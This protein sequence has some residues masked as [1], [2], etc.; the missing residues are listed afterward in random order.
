M[1]QA[2]NFPKN[3]RS[4]PRF[5]LVLTLLAIAFS[6]SA[7]AHA[8]S[9]LADGGF[10]AAG[11]GNVY[12]ATSTIDGGSWTVTQGA[13]YIDNLDPWVYDGANSL[14]LTGANLYAP[15]SIDQILTTV[16]GQQYAVNFWANA[17]ISNTF[18][19]TQ[20]GLSVSGAPTSIA[21]NGFPD[22]IDPLGN[23]ALFVDYSGLFTATTTSTDLSFTAIGNPSIGSPNF[24]V[25]IDDASVTPTPEP[26]SLLLMLTGILALALLAGRKHLGQSSSTDSSLIS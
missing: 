8:S 9:I 15:N 21:Q 4:S 24:S 19:L 25:I 5:S 6:L 11:G 26:G 22:Q 20:N 3:H 1:I 10:E 12:Y 17:D 14:N 13:V 2:S 18:S 7:S 16:V 23:S